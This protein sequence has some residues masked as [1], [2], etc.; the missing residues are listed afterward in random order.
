MKTFR[1][2]PEALKKL[3]A[4]LRNYKLLLYV[5]LAGV[6]MVLFSYSTPPLVKH[7][8]VI[9]L[10]LLRELPGDLP[11][12]VLRFALSLILLGLLPLALALVL[13]ERLKSIGLRS[14]K[15]PFSRFIFSLLFQLPR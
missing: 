8:L 1:A 9:H 6:V 15:P 5:L 12:Y 11:L 4:L 14:F 13:G 7:E 3:Q 10:P 2:F